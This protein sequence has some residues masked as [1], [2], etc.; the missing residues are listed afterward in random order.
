MSNLFT[1]HPNSVDETYTQHFF[2]ALNFSLIL[3]VLCLKAFIHALLPFLFETTVSDRIKT[4]CSQMEK[5]N[6]SM[7]SEK[8][9][10]IK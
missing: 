1:K 9:S 8:S 3:F 5:R 2:T 4:L 10:E 7:N 6:G